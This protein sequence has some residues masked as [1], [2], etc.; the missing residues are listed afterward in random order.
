MTPDFDWTP[1]AVE[2]LRELWASGMSTAAIA[3]EMK[4]SKNSIV[5]KAHRLQLPSRPSPIKPPTEQSARNARQCQLRRDAR[6]A[7]RIESERQA[8]IN[9]QRAAAREQRE[10][11]RV[12]GADRVVETVSAPRAPSACCFPLWGDRGRPTHRYCDEPAVRRGMCAE[13][14]RMCWR[15]L[16]VVPVKDAPVSGGYVWA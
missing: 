2:R 15:R 7:H 13:H 16:D 11:D 9:E 14:Y 6:N 3:R 12:T 8:A 4:T 10:I 5:G 1:A